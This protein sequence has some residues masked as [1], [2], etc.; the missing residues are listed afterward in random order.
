MSKLLET[1]NQ[2]RLN[3]GE[4]ENLN[5]LFTSEEIE[6]VIQKTLTYKSPRPGG[7][8]ETF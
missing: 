7:F 3:L 2:P 8:T 6:S 5:I 1:Y 4:T